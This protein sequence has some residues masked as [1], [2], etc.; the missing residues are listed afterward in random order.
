MKKVIFILLIVIFLT[1]LVAASSMAATDPIRWRLQSYAGPA[2]NAQVCKNAIDEFNIAANGEMVIDVYSADQLVPHGE[3][4]HALQDGTVD[5]AVSDDYSIG[6]P[7]DVAMFTAYFPIPSR[8][9]LD[10]DVLWNHYGLNEIWE[11][12]YGEIEGVTWLA[13]GSWDPCYIASTKP[14]EHVEDLKGLRIFAS[15]FSGKFLKEQFG[16]VPTVMPVEDVEMALQT[17]ML[18]GVSWSGITELYEIGWADSCDY[19]LTNP[20]S[21]A[22]SGGWFVN[23]KSW[24]AIP[25]HLQTLLRLAIAK[26]NYYRLTWYWDGEARQKA[27]GGKFKFTTIPVDEWTTVEDQREKY[28]DEYANESPRAAMVMQ[29]FRD[30]SETMKAAGPPYYSSK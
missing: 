12:S 1:T 5:M 26:S 2:L 17:G 28:W 11:E 18:D 7:A 15:L 13:Q 14:I 20:I 9:G 27:H 30:Y 24:E 19:L 4:F 25:P 23:T 21:G 22:W 29:A 10:V 3:L 8:I 6:S 16:V